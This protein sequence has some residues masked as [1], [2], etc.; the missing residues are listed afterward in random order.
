MPDVLIE[1]VCERDSRFE[2]TMEKIRKFYIG[3]TGVVVADRRFL[4]VINKNCKDISV[5][6]TCHL[7]DFLIISTAKPV[8]F[9]SIVA[10]E[11]SEFHSMCE[12]QIKQ[13]CHQS[14]KIV[15]LTLAQYTNKKFVICQGL[16]NLK[17]GNVEETLEKII[18]QYEYYPDS[19]KKHHTHKSLERSRIFEICKALTL[20]SSIIPSSFQFSIGETFIES[21]TN[22]TFSVTLNEK[23]QHFIWKT[24]DCDAILGVNGMY[25]YIVYT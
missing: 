25:R 16:M 11:D 18:E 19:F 2:D 4:S 17:H 12:Q 8:V 3:E 24:Y 1:N 21:L 23:Q 20:A 9:L 13:Y 5:C 15:K 22:E 6:K 14:A 7:C 10:F